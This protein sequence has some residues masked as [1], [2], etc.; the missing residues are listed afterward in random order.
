M[1]SEPNWMQNLIHQS[2]KKI[3]LVGLFVLNQSDKSN[4]FLEFPFLIRHKNKWIHKYQTR[5]GHMIYYDIKVVQCCANADSLSVNCNISYHLFISHLNSVWMSVSLW[6][7]KIVC[8][9][10]LLNSFIVFIDWP[11]GWNLPC[12]LCG[13]HWLRKD[14]GDYAAT[15]V[16]FLG[17]PWSDHGFDL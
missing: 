13:C 12:V 3:L 7:L 6:I 9:W 17:I 16:F 15:A 4:S 2:K 14:Q 11:F 5:V 1:H 8:V 10:L